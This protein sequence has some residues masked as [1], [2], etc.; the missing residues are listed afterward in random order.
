ML[1]V[2]VVAA[3]TDAEAALLATSLQQSFVNL[4]RGMPGML[5]P[6]SADAVL[7]FSSFGARTNRGVAESG[8][9]RFAAHRT[10]R[11]RAFYFR[12]RG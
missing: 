9:H 11:S 3:D 6:P 1:G 12:H 5:P 8:D 2:P 4:R 10:R 7:S